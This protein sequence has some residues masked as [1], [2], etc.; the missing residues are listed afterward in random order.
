MS[1]YGELE[2]IANGPFTEEKKQRLYQE[3]VT[4][5][6][7]ESELVA[8]VL[9]GETS[10]AK[11][12]EPF[13]NKKITPTELERVTASA[14]VLEADDI[15]Q[16]DASGGAFGMTTHPWTVRLDKKPS[17]HWPG[18]RRLLI[19][20]MTVVL[21]LA[22]TVIAGSNELMIAAG[23]TLSFLCTAVLNALAIGV[24]QNLEKWRWLVRELHHR[25]QWLDK[26]IAQLNTKDDQG[27]L[28]RE[29]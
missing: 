3:S 6:A 8:A 23:F 13:L 24:H 2:Y 21:M 15:L 16:L 10:F 9:R 14:L 17:Y 11:L 1:L 28:N 7:A 22:F 27:G 26:I 12:I 4:Q 18:I 20:T 29:A 5:W 19:I 25:A